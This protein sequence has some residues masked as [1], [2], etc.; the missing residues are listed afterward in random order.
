M[1]GYSNLETLAAQVSINKDAYPNTN[2]NDADFSVGVQGAK[3]LDECLALNVP[4]GAGDNFKTT[5]TIGGQ[6]FYSATGGGAAAGNR[7]DTKTYRT[8][9]D[10]MCYELTE[11]IH[12]GAIEN[13]D[14]S[15]SEINK[16]PIWTKLDAITQSFTFTK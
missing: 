7:Y 16:N 15:V 6:T 3:N 13:Y 5:T 9:K 2:F 12:T 1:D 11:T 14:P 8:F 10:N 4:E